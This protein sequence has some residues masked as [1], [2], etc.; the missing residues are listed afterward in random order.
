MTYMEHGR[1]LLGSSLN[2][3]QLPHNRSQTCL[4]S[5]LDPK[6]FDCIQAAF[7]RGRIRIS[8]SPFKASTIFINVSR[9]KFEV[10]SFSIRAING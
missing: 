8:I 1:R 9:L 5:R 7:L 4:M 3:G 6:K 10:L 2:I